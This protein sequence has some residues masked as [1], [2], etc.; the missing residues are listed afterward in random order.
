MVLKDTTHMCQ[1]GM[2]SVDDAGEG[3]VK[4]PTNMMADSVEVHRE[5]DKQCTP[6]SHRRVQLMSGR[7]AAAARY[8]KALCRAVCQAVARQMEIDAADLVSLKC[9]ISELIPAD[10]VSIDAV[11][12]DP[13]DNCWMKYWDDTNGKEL[14]A[15]LVKAARR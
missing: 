11:D 1:F 5:L 9:E 14:R 8:P 6:G 7:A 2:T 10:D 13:E 3:T 15:D 12:Q 4:K